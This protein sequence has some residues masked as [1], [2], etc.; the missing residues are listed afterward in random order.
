TLRCCIT[1]LA[2]VTVQTRRGGLIQDS[3][4][5]FYGVTE[6]GGAFNAGTVFELTNSGGM[7]TETTLYS[8]RGGRDG[9]FPQSTLTEDSKG[10]FYGTTV[11]GGTKT[12]NRGFARG[13]VFK[14]WY[15]GG[16]W[17]ERVLYRFHGSDDHA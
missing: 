17:K 11:Y 10:V 12:C 16:T 4:G 8:F 7:W 6:D 2:A 3:S 13:T 9:A 5:A 15:D 14:L 1:L